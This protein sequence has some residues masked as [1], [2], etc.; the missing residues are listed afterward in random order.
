MHSLDPALP[1]QVDDQLQLVQALVVG[2]LGLVARLDERL[3]AELDQLRNTAAE[4]GLLAEE[5]GLGLLRERRLDHA[6]AGCADRGAVRERKLAR[7]AGRVLRHCDHRR[8]PIPLRVE[9]PND[10]AGALRRDHDHVVAGRRRDAAVVD[11]EAVREEE[12]RARREVGRDLV[13]VERGL[14]AVGN[15]DRDELRILH[16]VGDRGDVETCILRRG[17]RR[18]ALA[19]ADDD[20]DPR[21]GHVERVGVALAPV[22]EHRDLPVEQVEVAGL[23]D[24]RHLQVLSEGV[25]VRL[26]RRRPIRPVRASSRTP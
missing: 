24:L 26:G 5:I 10:V 9:T 4:H 15:E 21:L 7:A 3:E 11:V 6:G 12:R 23:V 14:R 25:V 20:V 16:R 13:F 22:A 8:R 19:E 18:A 1:D 17:P 2:D